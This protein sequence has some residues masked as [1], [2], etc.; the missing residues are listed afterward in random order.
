[1]QSG[2]TLDGTKNYTSQ[3]LIQEEIGFRT[4]SAFRSLKIKPKNPIT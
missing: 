3:E 2:Q 4:A 1:M